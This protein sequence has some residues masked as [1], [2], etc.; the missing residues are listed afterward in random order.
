MKNKFKKT[1]AAFAALAVAAS[2]YAASMPVQ[3]ATADS[4]PYTIEAEDM[5]GA[6]LWTQ[7]YGPSPKNSSGKGFFYLTGNSASFTVTVPEDGMYT[8]TARCA[9]VLDKNGRQE[10]ISVNGIK[11]M[12]NMPYSEEWTDFSFGSFRLNKGVNTIEFISEYGYMAIDTVTVSA[13]P[14][15]DY[16]L[17]TGT[18]TDKNATPEAKS[19]MA[20]L[21][22][23]YGS[24]IIAGQQEIYGG[25][26]GGNYEWENEYLKDLT[27]KVPAIRGV[28]F[29]NYNPLYG[30]DDGTTERCIEWATKRGGIVTA[31]WHIN[32]PK[33]FENYTLGEK[34]DWKECTYKN[35]QSSDGSKSFDTRNVVIKGT[36]EYEYFQLAIK[37][38]AEQLKRLQDAGVPVIW[39]PLHEAQGNEGNY[40]DGTAWFWWGDRGADTYKKVWKLL[41]TTLTEEYGLH[42]LIWEFNS[43]DYTNSA[44]W[45]P[46]DDYV[47]IVAYDKYNVEYNRGDGKSGGPNLL[48]IPA[49]FDA[50]YALTN[51]KKMVAMAENDTIPAL[52]NLT[53][54][55]AG[56]LYFCPW[57]DGGE[58]GGTAFL[59][60]AYQDFDELKKIYQSDYCITLDELP[61]DLYTNGGSSDHIIIPQEITYPTNIKAN[62]SQ[63]YHQ[64]QFVWDKV[65]GA[66]KYGIAVYLAGK[67]RVQTSNITTNSYVTPK[68]LTPGMTYKVAIAARINGKWDTTNA[69]KNAVTVTIK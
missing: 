29:M 22:S 25:G 2:S 5:K 60:A 11:R 59:G 62:Y 13:T 36:K 39:R 46:G 47:D 33:D 23:V 45:Y 35:Y 61:V 16:T 10:S 19:L 40:S 18:L 6:E 69:I 17:A 37:D 50:L 12:K 20:Y 4:F 41:Y 14:K 63:Q 27:G 32:V 57:Y 49:K 43:Y 67:W 30:W 44:T 51:G 68:N 64:V 58:D 38:L 54:E 66:D 28:D 8:I 3:A 24:H 9:Q 1:M 26:H 56:W 52:D 21:K 15:H 7:N 31:S 65:K 42:N 53:V 55:D 48:A 34:L